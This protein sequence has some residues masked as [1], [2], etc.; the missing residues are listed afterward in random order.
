MIACWPGPVWQTKASRRP[1][2]RE[3][4]EPRGCAQK[5]AAIGTSHR[6]QLRFCSFN[7]APVL[8][9]YRVLHEPQGCAQR[10]FV[11]Q[12]A[13]G[14]TCRIHGRFRRHSLAPA[15]SVWTASLP[16]SETFGQVQQ[17][18]T[19][20]VQWLTGAPLASVFDECCY[21]TR[22]VC[23]GNRWEPRCGEPTARWTRAPPELDP[24]PAAGLSRRI[25]G[26]CGAPQYNTCVLCLPKFGRG[27][28]LWKRGLQAKRWDGRGRVKTPCCVLSLVSFSL[29][30][31]R[32]LAWVMV[33]VARLVL[34]TL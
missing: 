34:A 3:T 18:D 11:A 20:A 31:V 25:L 15:G 14:G 29:L 17:L 12:R 22:R 24:T 2:K 8:R 21:I 6:R 13:A 9:P 10:K 33:G 30:L 1:G 32:S 23:S 4:R 19:V 26:P 28:T 5:P 16:F 7:Q 27:T